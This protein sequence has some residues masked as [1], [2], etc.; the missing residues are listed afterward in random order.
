MKRMLC[1]ALICLTLPLLCP[2]AEPQFQ[3]GVKIQA[4]GKDIDVRVGHLVPCVTDW[5]GDQKKD[6]IVG[7]FSGGQISLYLNQGSNE[8]PEFKGLIDM[9]AGGKPIRL[10][11]G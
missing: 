8:K 9:R 5:N 4:D 2:A 1:C 10:D 6:L 3:T 11:A 7:Q